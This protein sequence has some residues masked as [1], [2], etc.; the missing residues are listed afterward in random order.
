MSHSSTSLP[1]RSQ[2]RTHTPSQGPTGQFGPGFAPL[3]KR[4]KG[5]SEGTPQGIGDQAALDH[6]FGPG[7]RGC[8]FTKESL[9]TL[10]TDPTPDQSFACLHTIKRSETPIPTQAVPDQS[11]EL[12]EGSS[13]DPSIISDLQDIYIMEEEE[14]LM[15]EA[16]RLS[17]LDAYPSPQTDQVPILAVPNAALSVS[18]HGL[19]ASVGGS[20][21]FTEDTGADFEWVDESQIDKKKS[22]AD[23]YDEDLELQRAIEESARE[24]RN[25]MSRRTPL[26]ATSPSPDDE[27][28][29]SCTS[30][31]FIMTR[32]EIEEIAQSPTKKGKEKAF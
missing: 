27:F 5:S 20:F 29:A 13:I 25:M 30:W 31:S 15:Q 1:G 10:K 6:G 8:E 14:A 24:Y 17:L 2:P 19:E 26:D 3:N 22:V 21:D 12:T 18:T 4:Q 7:L 23:T 11:Q 9:I 28:I 16:I 32:E